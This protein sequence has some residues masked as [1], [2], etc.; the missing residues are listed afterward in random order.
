MLSISGLT[1]AYNSQ[2]IFAGLDFA[3]DAGRLAVL[4]GPS[5]C[6]KST[7]FDVLTG[8]TDSQGGT[9]VW[10][11]RQVIHLGEV[12]AYMHQKDLLLPWS[13]L[14][15]NAL[16]PARIA[17]TDLE[18]ARQRAGQLFVNLGLGGYENY[19]PSQVSGGMR[20]RCALIRTLM[21]ERELILLDEPLSALDAITQ[22]SLQNL[23]LRVQAEFGKTFVMITH[24]IEEALLLADELYLLSARPMMIREKFVLTAAKPRRFNDPE[25]LSIKEHVLATLEGDQS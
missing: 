9:I 16:L 15:E 7:L 24:D 18:L 2:T 3:V 11:N 25:L 14:F 6:G 8:G 21:F 22:R 1:K 23:L 17:G 4:I 20:Q 13:T 19:F 10:N 5:G 12:T